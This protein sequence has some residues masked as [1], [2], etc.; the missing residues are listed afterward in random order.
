M[1]KITAAFLAALMLLFVFASCGQ[2]SDQKV[3]TV[4]YTLYE[5][6]NYL[7]DNNEL[8]GFDTELAKAVFE[9]LGYQVVFKEIEWS[10]KYTDLAAKNVDCLW[11]GFTANCA[12]DD[13]VQRSEKVDFS[14]NYMINQQAVVVKAD[15]ASE[16]TGAD[17]F[18]DKI[19]YAEAGSAGASY[20]DSAFEGAK[21]MDAI[22]QT[23]A[24]MEVKSGSAT[25]AVVDVL[26]AKSMVGTGDYADLAIVDSLTSDP[27]YYA[28]GFEKGSDLTAQV[29]AQLEKLAAD[30]TI[31]K[32]AEKYG[33][34]NAAILD[35]A[36][37]K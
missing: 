8:I 32:L 5:P 13:G 30:G 19:G 3:V 33:L 37:Q 17:Y 16:V 2:N 22:K 9:G 23:E 29:N 10:N 34:E 26:L 6:M 24:L 1:K 14:Y 31:K 36:D 35:Y 27:E 15:I 28:I 4:G 12:D 18:K 7:D 20:A 21:I 11:N 25:F